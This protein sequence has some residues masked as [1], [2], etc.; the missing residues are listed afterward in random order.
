VK[1]VLEAL[2]SVWYGLLA[3]LFCFLAATSVLSLLYGASQDDDK[4]LWVGAL[5]VTA[6]GWGVIR[7]S[8]LFIART[9]HNL[10]D[11]DDDNEDD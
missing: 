6:F 11:R 1:K 8:K 3:M 9:E 5:G 10:K 7:Y 2:L 4:S